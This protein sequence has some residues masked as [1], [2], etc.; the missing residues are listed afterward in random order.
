MQLVSVFFDR[1]RCFFFYLA[2][3]VVFAQRV[4]RIILVTVIISNVQVFPFCILYVMLSEVGWSFF[5]D[6]EYVDIAY[7]LFYNII[8]I[9]S[10]IITICSSIVTV[11]LHSLIAL[12]YR[13]FVWNWKILLEFHLWWIFKVSTYFSSGCSG[14][15]A[16]SSFILRDSASIFMSSI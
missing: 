8:L 7:Y 12:T 9:S 13:L 1:W 14:K 2:L 5:L 16:I 6:V 11:N 3:T 4:P 10:P 15:V